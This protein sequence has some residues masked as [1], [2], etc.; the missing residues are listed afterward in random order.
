VVDELRLAA[1][2][3]ERHYRQPRDRRRDVGAQ[4]ATNHVNA[5]I[6]TGGG[7]RRCQNAAVVD[8]EHVRVEIDGR[9]TTG[10]FGGGQPVRRGAEAIEDAGGRQ[11]ERA[12]ANRRHAGAAIGRPTYGAQ[13]RRGYG[14][15]EVVDARHKN[16]V[17]LG[18]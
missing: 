17:G 9:M 15:I 11:H 13:D 7:A 3:F 16:G 18:Q 12:G 8:V 6:E 10:Q 2:A 1:C 5:E 14:S 4:V